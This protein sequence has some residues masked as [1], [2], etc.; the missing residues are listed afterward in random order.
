MA[1]QQKPNE[2]AFLAR[3]AGIAVPDNRLQALV[4]GLSGTQAIC[5]ALARLDYGALPPASRFEAPAS[6]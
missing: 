4:I 3:L 5:D 2:V 6:R 1:E